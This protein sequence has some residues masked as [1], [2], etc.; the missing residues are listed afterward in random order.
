MAN[1]EMGFS[2]TKG[3]AKV[4][5]TYQSAGTKSAAM[6]A[7]G[8]VA[9]SVPKAKSATCTS[10]SVP[11]T[12][13]TRSVGTMVAVGVAGPVLQ[14]AFATVWEGAKDRDVLVPVATIK[15]VVMMAMAG[16]AENAAKAIGATRTVY[17]S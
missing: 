14:S 2:A 17:V 10:V 8:A 7:M 1:A 11:P 6:T 15:I 9:A 5:L 13:R 12:A 16:V 4:F 3:G